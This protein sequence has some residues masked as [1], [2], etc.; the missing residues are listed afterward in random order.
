MERGQL[1]GSADLIPALILQPAGVWVRQLI[2]QAHSAREQKHKL[3][4]L[5]LPLCSLPHISHGGKDK[6]LS[7]HQQHKASTVNNINVPREHHPKR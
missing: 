6:G 1:A 2:L 3:W 4:V 5:Y 7:E